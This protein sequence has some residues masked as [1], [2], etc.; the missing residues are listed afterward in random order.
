VK[1]NIASK[2]NSYWL[3]SVVERMK[4]NESEDRLNA[5]SFM[6]NSTLLRV[7][8]VNRSISGVTVL[9]SELFIVRGG[10]HVSV[11]N[12]NNFTLTRNISITGSSY[13]LAIVASPRYNCLY[14]T[15]VGLYVVYRYNLSNNVITNWS[16]GGQ[17]FGLSLTSTCNV[18]VTLSDT[19]RIK[20]FTPD[21]GLIRYF[22]LDR[23]IEYPQHCVHLSSG[24]FVISHGWQGGHYSESLHQVC[25]LNSST[26]SII[27]CHG[28][29]SGSGVG[30]L[31]APVHLAVDRHGNV[32][33][34]DSG[35]NRI[36]L[37]SPSLTNLGYI[38]TPG[39]RLN[40]PWALHLDEL[41][42]RLYIGEYANTGRVFVLTV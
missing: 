23:S 29:S 4:D 41:T 28:R 5:L 13:L 35:N 3:F 39:H 40:Q 9:D 8:S 14:I 25:I 30:Q 33:V 2:H 38:E 34:A 32:L 17:G 31:N 16:V 11:Y 18:L 27:Q 37:L 26:G 36:E 15:D 20:E 6:D 21:G 12:T 19:K 22:I 7:I 10:S 24:G 42:H 1:N